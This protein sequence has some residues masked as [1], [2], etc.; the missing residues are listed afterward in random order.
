VF[1]GDEDEPNARFVRLV[2]C[3]HIIEYKALDRYM[4]AEDDSS[5]VQLKGCPRCKTPVRKCSR[6]GTQINQRL[7]DIEMVKRAIVGNTK[8]IRE[9]VMRT[10]KEH[11]SKMY[12]EDE[13]S[14]RMTR[15]V[16]KTIC[17]NILIKLHEFS[18]GIKCMTQQN[19]EVIQELQRVAT[20]IFHGTSISSLHKDEYLAR[21]MGI[22]LSMCRPRLFLSAQE[23]S[24]IERELR[25][26]S[27]YQQYTRFQTRV[28]SRK[29]D[30]KVDEKRQKAKALLVQVNGILLGDDVFSSEQETDVDDKL[31]TVKDLLR[32]E[33]LDI[34]EEEKKQIVEAIGLKRGHWFK[35]PNSKMTLFKGKLSDSFTNYNYVGNTKVSVSIKKT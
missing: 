9:Q 6:Y 26:R 5:N 17:R 28:E 14:Q 25:R 12:Y 3:G 15:N 10:L 2:D 30:Y 1:F 19:Y 21:R 27:F 16:A 24:D 23:A 34:T 7:N 33:G 8:H 20:V 29:Y 35:C 22:L 32:E 13:S 18:N 11:S 4:S 31:R